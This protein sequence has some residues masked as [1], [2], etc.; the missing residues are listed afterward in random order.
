MAQCFRLE[1][2]AQDSFSPLFTL[3]A[4]N[5]ILPPACASRIAMLC[6]T[7]GA[8]CRHPVHSGIGPSAAAR[9]FQTSCR[10]I[11]SASTSNLSMKRMSANGAPSG[12]SP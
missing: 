12:R 6:H 1:V 3:D 4:A 2:E 10:L 9:S 7:L 5:R 11:F 8:A